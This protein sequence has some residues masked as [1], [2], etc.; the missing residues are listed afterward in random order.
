MTETETAKGDSAILIAALLWGL[1]PVV[2]TVTLGAI[3]PLSSLFFS[4]IFATIF[5]VIYTT[6]KGL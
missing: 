6:I 1:F 3:G 2:T 5:F 4:T